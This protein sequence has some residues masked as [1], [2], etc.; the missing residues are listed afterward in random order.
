MVPAE[1]GAS[2]RIAGS[3]GLPVAYIARVNEER[4]IRLEPDAATGAP[5]IDAILGHGEYLW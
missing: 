2:L 3:S 1:D 5:E 4:R